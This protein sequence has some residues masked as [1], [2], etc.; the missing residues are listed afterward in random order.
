MEPASLERTKWLEYD[1]LH[2]RVWIAGQRMHH[3]ATGS[4]VAGTACLGLLTG[5]TRV[6]RS[7]L[8]IVAAGGA[9]MAHD[10]KDRAL[11]FQP[12]RGQQR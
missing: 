10:W 12:G 4:L 8:A 11:W 1:A 7:L 5:H 9:L 6:G 3:G 2:H